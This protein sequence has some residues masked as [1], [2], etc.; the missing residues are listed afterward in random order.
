MPHATPTTQRPALASAPATCPGLPHATVY[1]LTTSR[2]VWYVLLPPLCRG[3]HV[4]EL[5]CVAS[6]SSEHRHLQDIGHSS[7]DEGRVV[8]LPRIDSSLIQVCGSNPQAV[9]PACT[10]LTPPP[11]SR[12]DDFLLLSL[13]RSLPR[14]VRLGCCCGRDWLSAR[15]LHS[16]VSAPVSMSSASIGV[17]AHF[18]CYSILGVAP[19]LCSMSTGSSPLD[20]P[21]PQHRV[22]LRVLCPGSRWCTTLVSGLVWSGL[23]AGWYG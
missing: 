4:E 20:Q 3:E 15:L 23:V 19:H 22:W 12:K 8:C 7:I 14:C 10:L 13:P 16:E 1:F 9:F 2:S 18:N 6:C 21:I 11:A 17:P 5:P